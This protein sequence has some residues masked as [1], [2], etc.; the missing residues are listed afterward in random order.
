M[1]WKQRARMACG[2]ALA[3][4]VAACGG[5]GGGND[6]PATAAPEQ[7]NAGP[8][9]AASKKVLLVGVDGATYS[10]LQSA[11]AQRSLPNLATLAITPAATGGRLGTTTEQAPLNGPSWA[12][13]LSGSWADRHG[14]TDDVAAAAGLKAPS[15]FQYLRGASA[16]AGTARLRL[17]G[18]TSAPLLP[19]LLK[20]DVTA[21]NLDSLRDCN[22]DDNCVTQETI[23]LVQSGYDVVFAQYT[24]PDA[25][26][27]AQG[28][29][30]GGYATAL[31]G[32][33]QALGKLLAAV[34][35]RRQAN[36]NEDWLVAVTTSHGLDATGATTTLPTVQNRTAFIALN[37][38]FNAALAS[39][40]PPAPANATALSALPTEADLLP[41]VLAHT[42]VAVPAASYKLDGSALTGNVGVRA[43]SSVVGAYNASLLLSWQNPTTAGGDMALLR[44]GVQI[45]TLPAGTTGYEDKT[46]NAPASGIYR[47]NYTLVRNG[48]PASMLAQIN[49]VKPIVLADTL[50]N[51]LSAYYSFETLPA[52][53]SKGTTAIGP[54]VPGTD[55]GS[56]GGDNFGGKSLKVDSRI[57]AYQLTQSGA[58][59]ALAPQFTIGFWFK[60]DCTQGNGTGEPILSN[61]NYVSGSNAGIAL[62][63]FGSCEI[64][65][66]IGSGGKRDDIQGMKF[67]AN[68]WA[69]VALSINATAKTF[70]AYII[71]PVLGLQKT[72]NKAIANTDVTKLNGL[73]TKVWG[74]NDD[75]THAYVPNNSGALKGVMEFND[76]AMWT[77]QLSLA[78]LQTI[79]GSRQ[80]LSTLNP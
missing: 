23:K 49:Y 57:D 47:F 73:A 72:E 39:N 41:T 51:N 74:I 55:G 9:G 64:R 17:G 2:L 19:A 77:R 12:T 38:P 24:A 27:A 70:S 15:V 5:G 21:G 40:L 36:A 7:S 20:A 62:G 44:D 67:S 10:Q 11:M 80:P 59:I 25:A 46:L 18:A 1:A 75:A 58:D 54:W 66:N 30:G 3:G 63:L 45:A 68:Q 50:R 65:F 61:K 6:T 42:G 37:K 22:A 29:Q 69:Y 60:S 8:G 71:D 4:T 79:A 34:Q 13:V 43:L 31:S 28:F 16:T 35:A 53:D 14:V 76:L 52:T 56:L 48:V 26:A 32:F 33:D 78:E